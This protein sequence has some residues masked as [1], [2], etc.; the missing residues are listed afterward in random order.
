MLLPFL[1]SVAKTQ[2]LL[3]F[4]MYCLVQTL[5]SI[6]MFL[7]RPSRWIIISLTKFDPIMVG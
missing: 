7:P 1:L 2:G 4:Q 6:L 5:P 3:P